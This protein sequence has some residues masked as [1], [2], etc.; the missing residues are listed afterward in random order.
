MTFSVL[1]IGGSFD[2]RV[3]KVEAERFEIGMR[4][5]LTI[6]ETYI[7]QDGPIA[8]VLQDTQESSDVLTVRAKLS[9]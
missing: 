5:C 2:G 3:A 8:Q 1:C 9:V 6:S 4:L 7:I